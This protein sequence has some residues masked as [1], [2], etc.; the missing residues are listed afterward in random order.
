M[1]GT[2]IYIFSPFNSSYFST[3]STSCSNEAKSSFNLMRMFIFYRSSLFI[4]STSCFKGANIYFVSS[5]IA[6]ISWTSIA[7]SITFTE[8]SIST[9]KLYK[10]SNYN[11]L[12]PI[13]SFRLRSSSFSLLSFKTFL[14]F[15][16]SDPKFLLNSKNLWASS[17]IFSNS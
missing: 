4:V 15:I 17:F 13:F 2:K 9:A 14:R 6:D 12:K 16:I 8:S 7:L 10:V 3:V 5:S 11:L 1:C